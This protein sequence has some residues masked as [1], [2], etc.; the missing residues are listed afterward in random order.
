MGKIDELLEALRFYADPETYQVPG[1]DFSQMDFDL[2]PI[3]QDRGEKA[4]AIL[5]H[6]GMITYAGKTVELIFEK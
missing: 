5:D 3:N 4:R 6:I 1:S 2:S